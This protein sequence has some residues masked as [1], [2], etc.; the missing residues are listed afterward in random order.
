M[1]GLHTRKL[2]HQGEQEATQE[3]PPAGQEAELRPTPAD[4]GPAQPR[5]RF[6]PQGCCPAMC[7]WAGKTGPGEAAP[8]PLPEQPPR[9]TPAGRR[10]N[11][12]AR[13]ACA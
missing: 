2:K 10:E 13:L 11:P 8:G 12:S 4:S 5:R 3:S 9:P 7:H 1:L 6:D